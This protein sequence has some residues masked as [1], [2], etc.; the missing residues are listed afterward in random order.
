MCGIV[1]IVQA[2][3][4]RRYDADDVG[5]MAD[6]IV[7]RGPDDQGLIEDQNAILGMRRL[8]IIDLEGGHQPIH[9]EDRTVWVVNNGEIY[10]YK[11]LR[12][13]LIDR[14]HRFETD[15]DTE[16]LVHLYE[17]YGE[18]FLSHLEGMFAV[19]LWDTKKR[20]LILARDRIGIKPFY[21]WRMAV[22]LRSRRRSSRL[23]RCRVFGCRR[24]GAR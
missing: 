9:N 18:D 21:Y 4:R 16:V 7:H 22:A 14:G 19:A 11:R 24:R 15:S 1:G 2:D 13:T 12:R 23:S 10:N 17:E 5:R 20:K 8:S 6:A 3:S